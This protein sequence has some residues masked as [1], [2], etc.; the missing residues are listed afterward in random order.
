MISK[1][2]RTGN[3]SFIRPVTGPGPGT[4]TSAPSH[5]SKKRDFNKGNTFAFHPPA[6]WSCN[7]PP[8]VNFFPGPGQYPAAEKKPTSNPAG[9][10]LRSTSQRIGFMRTNANPAPGDYSV[11][12][13]GA[14][15][16]LEDELGG[17]ATSPPR[18]KTTPAFCPPLGRVQRS[19][20]VRD[21]PVTGDFKSL[22]G[23]QLFLRTLGAPTEERPGPSSYDVAPV[24]G[25][26]GPSSRSIRG[27]SMFLSDT[28]GGGSG[29]FFGKHRRFPGPGAYEPGFPDGSRTNWQAGIG[30]SLRSSSER[31][32][33]PENKG[34]PGP[35]FYN[36]PASSVNTR[37]SFHLNLTEKWI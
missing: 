15:E 13:K 27:S 4:Y 2:T 12:K 26:D 29:G 18:T 35:A 21:F 32:L 23:D 10:S 19:V 5:L 8:I 25:W 17:S 31:Q 30:S 16:G 14:F 34:A 6:N 20:N 11:S 9:P 33:L 37:K 7:G 22:K 24:G 36:P 1:S 28:V 3:N